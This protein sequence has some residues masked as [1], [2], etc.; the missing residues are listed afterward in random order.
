[1]LIDE[2][3]HEAL[4]CPK[5]AK[6][7]AKVYEFR[8]LIRFAED[9]YFRLLRESDEANA[10][11]SES[12]SDSEVEVAENNNDSGKSANKGDHVCHKMSSLIKCWRCSLK[13]ISK[14]LPHAQNKNSTDVPK[15]VLNSLDSQGC[16]NLINEPQLCKNVEIPDIQFPQIKVEPVDLEEK[17]LDQLPLEKPVKRTFQCRIC[18]K[19]MVTRISLRNHTANTHFN[20]KRYFCDLCD[21]KSFYKSSMRRHIFLRHIKNPNNRDEERKFQCSKCEKRFF[22]PHELKIHFAHAHT[23]NSNPASMFQFSSNLKPNFR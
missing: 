19:T 5:C 6:K 2:G 22:T 1:M 23:G 14:I 8:R 12:D 15:V 10:A 16:K 3:K 7:L 21:E 17:N 11:Q 18:R 20:V 13:N 4:I 9:N